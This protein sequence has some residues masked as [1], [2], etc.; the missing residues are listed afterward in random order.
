MIRLHFEERKFAFALGVSAAVH[1]VLLAALWSFASGTI[2][3]PILPMGEGVVQAFLVWESV[4]TAG[5]AAALPGEKRQPIARPEEAPLRAFPEEALPAKAQ[6][7]TGFAKREKGPLLMGNRLSAERVVKGVD[8]VE[9][10]VP[11]LPGAQPRASVGSGAEDAAR[12]WTVPS[13]LFPEREAPSGAEGEDI[14]AAFR[15]AGESLGGRGKAAPPLRRA[16]TGKTGQEQG[17]AGPPKS[18][19]AEAVPRYRD[20]ARP[21]YPPLARVRGYQG[22]VVLIVEVLADGRVGQVGIKRSAGHV[23][24]DRAALEAVRTWRFDPGR[25]EGRAVTMSVEVP[26]RFVLNGDF[27]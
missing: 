10:T 3:R 7:R 21:D 1:A 15:G 27:T 23:I 19:D 22:V 24:L 25:R 17:A 20:N 13:F 14:A 12:E 26:V 6:D 4:S 18:A 8:R 9:F 11:S 2:P 16:E 5:K